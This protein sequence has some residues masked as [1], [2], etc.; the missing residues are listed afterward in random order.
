MGHFSRHYPLTHKL[1][2]ML[3]CSHCGSK[4]CYWYS[5]NASV[6]VLFLRATA[7]ML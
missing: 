2:V 5:S 7:Y 1:P 6:M 3:V 4:S